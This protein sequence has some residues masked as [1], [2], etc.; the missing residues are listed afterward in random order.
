MPD[1]ITPFLDAAIL[2]PAMILCVR[3][4]GLRSFSKMSSYDFAVTVGFGSVLA[5]TVVN[6]GT[7][8]WQGLLG[9]AAL[10][11]TQWVIG[12]ARARFEAVQTLTDNEPLLLMVEGKLLDANMA[13][14]RV[15]AAEIA[16]KLRAANVSSLDEV[17]AVVLETT[18][19]VSVI[20]GDPVDDAI[21][22]RVRTGDADRSRSALR[23]GLGA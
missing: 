2:V 1:W 15:T 5:G 10:F 3:L 6:P 12:L 11:A 18:G 21:L 20:T 23:S 13:R 16:G 19:D 8:W 17:R 7:L 22:H 9:L 14:A 4:T